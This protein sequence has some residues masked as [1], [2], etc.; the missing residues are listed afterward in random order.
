MYLLLIMIHLNS[1]TA[2]PEDI[3]AHNIQQTGGIMS[4]KHIQHLLKHVKDA[5]KDID[6]KEG[7]ILSFSDEHYRLRVS[8]YRI[9]MEIRFPEGINN[10]KE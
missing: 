5:V 2:N 1:K 8:P 10:S 4:E 3:K 7:D 9:T 6:L